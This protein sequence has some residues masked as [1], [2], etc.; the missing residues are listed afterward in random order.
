M[1]MEVE[2]YGNDRHDTINA[3]PRLNGVGTLV[4]AASRAL[5]DKWSK[6]ACSARRS[7]IAG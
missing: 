1:V 3:S 7:R 5:R 2:E 4:A 6:S